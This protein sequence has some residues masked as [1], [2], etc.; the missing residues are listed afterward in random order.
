MRGPREAWLVAALALAAALRVAA[1]SAAFP[2]FN[3]IDEHLHFDL[4]HK[5]SRGFLPG[6]E[7]AR[8]DPAGARLIA[9]HASPEY[10]GGP[11]AQPGGRYPTP[12]EIR[13][14]RPAGSLQERMALRSLTERINV[15][16]ESPPA[17]YALAGA[18]LRLGRAL[19][20]DGLR[21]LYWL[22]WLGAGFAAA[23]VVATWAVLRGRVG[24]RFVRLG[25]PVLVAVWPN[26][27]LYGITP[28]GFA[29]LLGAL[30]L[31]ALV[32]LREGGR[33]HGEHLA[34]GLLFGVAFLVKYP[35]VVFAGLAAVYGA[36]ALLRAWRRGEAREALLRWGMLGLGVVATA[37]WWLARNLHV[38]GSA[39]GQDRKLEAMGWSVQDADAMLAHPLVGLRGWP[40]FTWTFLGSLWR[41]EFVWQGRVQHLAWMDP[42]YVVSSLLLLGVA[43]ATYWRG[44]RGAAPA[45][46]DTRRCRS[47]RLVEGTAWAVL[48]ASVAV[49]VVLSLWFD[50]GVEEG[51][52]SRAFPYLASGRL[53]AGAW[54]AFALLYVSGLA[55]AFGPAPPRIAAAG[56]W[57][58]L[59]VLA[60]LALASEAWTSASAFASAWNWYHLR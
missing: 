37:G 32:R 30:A 59:G 43:G 46:E 35:A 41:G 52:L 31:G 7:P 3:P 1:F 19:G 26:D 13:A 56:R 36:A 9:D 45:P 49:L 33:S 23:T 6:R 28:D 25:A 11:E 22:R 5:Y 14:A 4:V 48:G 16:A 44:R 27:L 55:R 40:D 18:W 10:L 58:A 54:P 51:P 39:S 29:A 15:E 2:F 60:A 17:Y 47:Q 24:D 20:L 34:A 57:A 53:V 21:L 12:A 50:F 38:L 42:V 8:F